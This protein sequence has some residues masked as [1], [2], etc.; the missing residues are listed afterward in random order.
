MRLEA[1]HKAVCLLPAG[2]WGVAVSG[3][4]DS[5]AL[6]RLVHD[7]PEIESTVVHLNHQAR[8]AQSDA[9]AQFVRRL[10][11]SL[12]VTCEIARRDQI[13]PALNDLPRN[14]SARFRALR[15]AWFKSVVRE[16]NLAGVMLA[17]HADDQ[18]E[19]IFFRLLRGSGYRGSTG[20]SQRA[21]IA[22]MTIL[23]PLLMVRRAML[24]EYL[25]KLGESWREDPSNALPTYARNRIRIALAGKDELAE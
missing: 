16:K 21:T 12:N 11:A 18:A 22:G 10:A 3:G 8:G 1:L 23:R 20:M 9:D 6:L 19:T 15:L 2:R 13:E 5:V 25:T 24:R 7:L 4:A 17:H 14:R